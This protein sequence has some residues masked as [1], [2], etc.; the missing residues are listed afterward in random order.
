[1]TRSVGSLFALTGRVAL[2]T[3]AAGPLG[4]V[5]A[6]TLA[7]LGAAV[8]LVDLDQ[9]GVDD[10][11][12]GLA[13][14]YGVSALGLA[15]D[16]SSAPAAS[17]LV[18]QTVDQLGGLD[19]LVNNAALTG[20]S[21]VSGYAAPFDDQSEDAFDLAVAV[22]L[23]A[24]FSLVRAARLH[25]AA[26]GFGS[27]VNISS[28]YGLLGPVP[29]LYADTR[30]VTPAAYAASKGGLVQ[31][32]RHLATSIAPDIRVNAIAPG[33][34]RRDQGAGFIQRYAQRTPLRRMGSEDDI[35]GA[36][37]WLAGDGSRT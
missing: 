15:A 12:A 13:E 16:L 24:P 6:A 36:L 4:R 37:A 26:R 1:M 23:R 27:V 34:L 20:T 8:A 9:G 21:P 11:A 2:V 28:I 7:E 35:R 30:M 5:L 3:G 14:A 25:L 22:N 19:I 29:D 33:G 17:A 31:L 32:T 10:L 18:E